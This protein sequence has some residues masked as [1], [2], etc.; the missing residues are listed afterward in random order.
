M[1]MDVRSLNWVNVGNPDTPTDWDKERAARL[2]IHEAAQYMVGKYQDTKTFNGF[3]EAYT[4]DT[5][6][7]KPSTCGCGGNN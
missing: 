5:L 4:V 1:G 3:D 7:D 2:F 6:I